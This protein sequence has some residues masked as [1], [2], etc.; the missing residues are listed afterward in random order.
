MYTVHFLPPATK[1]P[2]LSENFRWNGSVKFHDL[3]SATLADSATYGTMNRA[4]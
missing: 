4:D 1:N 3:F 2:D